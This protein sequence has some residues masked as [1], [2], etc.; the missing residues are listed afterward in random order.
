MSLG[1]GGG[2]Q[3]ISEDDSLV[4]YEYF[5]YNLSFEDREKIFDG[6]ILINKRSLL[7]PERREKFRRMPGGRRRSFTKIILRDVPIDE[8]IESGD[9]QIENCSHAW[10]F[11][12]CGVDFMAYRLCREIFLDYQ[13]DGILIDRR[14]YFV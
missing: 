2:C 9:V 12:P 8:L 7:E 1:Y 14:G 3:K 13:R 6:L 4:L 10:K 5:S 11:L